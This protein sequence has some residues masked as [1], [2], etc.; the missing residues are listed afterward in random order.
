MTKDVLPTPCLV[1]DEALFQKN[2]KLMAGATQAIGIALRPHVKVHKSVDVA[3]IQIA[4]G[5]IGL[6][7]ATIAEAELMSRAG[8]RNVMW[9]K[10][11]ASENNIERAIALSSE[12]ACLHFRDRRSAGLRLGGAGGGRGT[13]SRPGAGLGVCRNEPAGNRERPARSGVSAEDRQIQ[14][15]DV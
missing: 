8:M 2:V 4:Q 6:T 10:Q 12:D 13:H 15:Y 5:A 1:V 3:R 7:C 9:T 14:A 11:P